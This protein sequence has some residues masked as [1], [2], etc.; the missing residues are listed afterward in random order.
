MSKTKVHF[1]RKNRSI[2]QIKIKASE[3]YL[4]FMG[5]FYIVSPEA[6]NRISKNGLMAKG[7]EIFFFEGN[8]SPIPFKVPKENDTDPSRKYLDDMV[9]VNFLEQTGAPNP[10]KFRNAMKWIKPIASPGGM[11]KLILAVLI[12]GTLVRSWILSLV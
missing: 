12:I 11:M 5:G 10:E 8:S 2:K 1:L 4:E 7:S 9:Y 3:G 6:I